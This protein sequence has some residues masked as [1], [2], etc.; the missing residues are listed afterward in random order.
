MLFA[1]IVRVINYRM[2]GDTGW[3]IRLCAENYGYEN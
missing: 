2:V 1:Y 3:E